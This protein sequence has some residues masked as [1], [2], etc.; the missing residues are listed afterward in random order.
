MGYKKMDRNMTFAEVDYDR[1]S[2]RRPKSPDEEGPATLEDTSR[3]LGNLRERLLP[4]WHVS[5]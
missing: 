3:R 4:G 5:G 2:K 1:R